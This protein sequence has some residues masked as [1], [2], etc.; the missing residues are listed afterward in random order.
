MNHKKKKI[1][2]GMGSYLTAVLIGHRDHSI[3]MDA[4]YLFQK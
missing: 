4:V 1:W 2:Q 3:S